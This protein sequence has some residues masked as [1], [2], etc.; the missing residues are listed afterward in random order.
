MKFF[1]SQHMDNGRQFEP[2]RRYKS[3][4]LLVSGFAL[5]VFTCSLIFLA[6]PSRLSAQALSGISGTVT[7]SSG[8]ALPGANVTVTNVDTNVEKSTTTSAAGTFNLSDLNP[9]SYTVKISAPNFQTSIKQ[10]VRVEASRVSNADATLNP[11]QVN[12]QVVV[13]S[14]LISLN[15]EAPT[16]ATTL[17]PVLEQALPNIISGGRGRQIDAFIFLAPG[18]TGDTFSHRINGGVD[19]QNEILFNGVPVAQ[20]ETQGYQTI[21]NPPFEM[22]SE[23]SVVRDT[24]SAQYGLAAGGVNYRFATGTNDLH[25]DAFEIL[26]NDMFDAKGPYNATVPVDKEHNYGFSVGGPVRI[27]KVYNGRDKTFFFFTTEWDRLNQGAGGTMTVPT[28]AMKAGDFSNFIDQNGKVIPIF[29]PSNSNCT[30]NGNRPGTPF[31]NNVIPTAC[32]SKNSASL[33]Q[34]FPNPDIQATG[35]AAFTNNLH[36][37]AGVSPNRQYQFGFTIDQTLTNR[38]TIHYSEWR[39]KYTSYYHQNQLAPT[40]PLV[41]E[42]YQPQLG[43]GFFLNYSYAISPNLVMTAGA[44]WMGELNNEQ[45]IAPKGNFSGLVASDGQMPAFNFGDGSY[46][47]GDIGAAG[48]NGETTSTNRKLG[49]S[50]ANNWLWTRGRHTFNIGWE[51]RRTYQDDGECRSCLGKL[52]FSANT[53][54]DPST[55]G[56]QNAPV[57]GSSFAS[58]LLG[59]VDHR[60]RAITTELRLRNL[61]VSPYIQDAVKLNPKL[62]IN[63]GVRWDIMR[64]F[65]ENNNNVVFFDPTVP[66][67]LGH[68]AGAASRLGTCPNCVGWNHADTTWTHFSPRLGFDYKINDKMVLNAGFSQNYL[69]GGSYEYGTNKVAVNYGNLLNGVISDPS[70]GSTKATYG[71]WDGNVLAYPTAKTFTA[72]IANGTDAYA[73]CKNCTRSP[74]LLAFNVGL[75]RELPHN[76]FLNVAYVTNRGVHLSGQM[77]PYNQLASK[78]LSLGSLLTESINSPDAKAAG[79]SEPF[80]GFSNLWGDNATVRQALRP[81]PQFGNITNDFDYSGASRYNAM[82]IELDRR[83]SNGLSALVSYNL[84]RMMSN[85]NSG[86]TTFVARPLDKAN[87][88]PEWTVDNNDQTHIFKLAGTYELPIGPGKHFLNTKNVAGQVLGGWQISPTIAYHSG[89]PMQIG[90]SS[91]PLMS[92]GNRANIIPGVK[93]FFG[94]HNLDAGTLV[95]NPAAFQDPGNYAL[96]NSPREIPSLRTPWGFNED[97]AVAKKFFF[98]E[99]TNLELRMTYFNVLNRVIHGGPDTTITDANFGTDIKNMANTERRGMAQFKLNF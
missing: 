12:E 95:L 59:Q 48:D 46:D 5:V 76:L 7:D 78:Y 26:R 64:P 70:S 23:F 94:Y 63:V 40:N 35:V 87:Q 77:N 27:P 24:F 97:V 16:Q 25:G 88:S 68:L 71:N 58:F 79:L 75:Q 98:G 45:N 43:T 72:D 93:Q 92:G 34:Y 39:N 82:Q 47:I 61:D 1:W 50:F 20:S 62:T 38:Q 55:F 30:A 41:G 73:F 74:Y 29:N 69:D 49:L 32:F 14:N 85:T 91:D 18:V 2:H 44:G 67:P 19:F 8:A 52:W 65:T 96:G 31:V 90:A 89:T 51:F 11:G 60:Y 42:K 21:L 99:K 13:Q 3:C 10:G 80:I 81:Y 54:K 22:V 57:S 84:S 36:S 28:T 33:L 17:E 56:Q 86:F 83:F 9:G 4:R 53:T 66:N 37:Q 6:M 15:T